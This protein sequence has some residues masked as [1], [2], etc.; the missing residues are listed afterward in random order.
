MEM[1]RIAALLMALCLVFQLV[2]APAGA[3][4]SPAITVGSAEAYPGNSFYINIEAT[5]LSNLASLDLEIYYDSENLTL[6]SVTNGSLLSGGLVS[7]N[8]ETPGVIKLSAAWLSGISED[9]RLLRLLF[10]VNSDAAPGTYRVLAAVGDAHDVNLNPV[11]ISRGAGTVTVKDRPTSA[12]NF[13]V[14]LSFAD[15]TTYHQG[16][17]VNVSLIN[18]GWQSFASGDFK[19][20]Y[21]S[22]LFAL[23]SVTLRSEM[24]VEGA[25]YSVN[26]D[27][28]GLVKVSYASVQP[29]SCY[30]LM[31]FV[32]TV[33]GDTD[34]ETTMTA[35]ATDVYTVDLVPYKPGSTNRSLTLEKKTAVPDYPDLY[36]TDLPTTVGQEGTTLLILEENSGVAAADFTV[37]YDPE[38]YACLEVTAAE[39]LSET[40]GMVVINPTFDEGSVK[41]SYINENGSDAGVELVSIQWK[42]LSSPQTHAEVLTGGTGIVNASF[43]SVK[44]DLVPFTGCIFD[45]FRT[46][47]TCTMDGEEGMMC[48]AC[49]EKKDVTVLSATGHSYGAAVTP[50]TCTEQGFTTHTC[51]VCGHSYVDEY[52]EATG[53]SYDD[54]YT[55]VEATCTETGTRKHD[56]RNCDHS[57]TEVTDALGHAYADGICTRCGAPESYL[58]EGKCGDT[59]YWRMGE[60]G[61]LTIFGTGSMYDFSSSK[62]G[63]WSAYKDSIMKVIV[64]EGATTI[65]SNAFRSYTSITDVKLPGTLQALNNSCFYGCE[66]LTSVLLTGQLKTIG[67]SA[68]SRCSNLE[69]VTLPDGLESIGAQAFSTCG[70]LKGIVI[71]DGVTTLGNFVFSNCWKLE[72][73]NIPEGVT[74]LGTMAFFS[75]GML[76]EIIIP[77]S[78]VSIGNYAFRYCDSLTSVVIPAGV[79]SLGEQAFDSCDALEEMWICSTDCTYA[80]NSLDAEATVFCYENST[81]HTYAVDNGLTY[82]AAPAGEDLG[83]V[84]TSQVTPP[85]C[86]EQ[87][88]T[89]HTCTRC[90][91]AVTDSYVDMLP[92]NF[93]QW[94]TTQEPGCLTTGTKQHDCRDCGYSETGTLDAL[95]HDYVAVVTEP[96]CTAQ[97]YTTHTCS[98]CGDSYKDSYTAALGHEYGSWYTVEEASCT[99]TGTER[100][101]CVRCEHY[102]TRAVDALGHD[103]VSAVTAPTCLEQGYT[104]HTCSRCGDSYADTYVTA[105]G[106]DYGQWITDREPTC[107]ETGSAHRDC[108]RCDSSETKVLA[109]TG[110]SYTDTV[111]PPTCTERGYTTHT[112]HCG[113]SYI[114]SYVAALGHA[115]EA[116][117]TAPTCLERGYTTY[118]CVRCDDTYVDDYVDAT[119]HS[120]GSWAV[121]VPATCTETG[122]DRRTCQN[123]DYSETRE[124]AIVPHSYASAVT[125]PDCVKQG[126]TT[127]TCNECG[128]SYVSDYTEPL[129]HAWDEGRVTVEPT[130]E[131]EGERVYTCTRCGETKTEVIPELEHVHSYVPSVTA[132]TCTEQGYTTYTCRCGDSYVQ[133]YVDALGH[134]YASEVTE[135]TC[136]EQ[137]Y[138]THTCSRCDHTYTDGYTEPL[139]HDYGDWVTDKAATCTEDGSAHRDCAR[140]ADRETKVLNKLGHDYV[141]VVTDPTCLDRGYTTH[142]CNRCH[143]TYTD[144]YTAALGHDYASVVTAPTCL[145]QGYTTH[146]CSRCDESYVDSYVAAL[147]HAYGEW[148]TDKAATCT[149]EGSAH[150][151]CDRCDSRETKV[152]DKLGHD[153]ESTVTDPTC[154][155]RGY[156]THRCSRCGNSYVDSYVDALGHAY[157][158]WITDQAPTCTEDGS[159]SRTC[160]RCGGRETQVLPMTGHSY[161]AETTAPTCTERGYT[162]YTC[163]CG[164][165]YTDNYVDTLGHDYKSVV[166]APTCTEQGYTT[167]TCTRCGHS[168][169]DAWLEALGHSWDEGVITKEP[170]EEE[171]GEMVYTCTVCGATDTK[172]LPELGHTHSYSA[173]VTA[174]TCTEEGYTTYTCRC[175]DS[176][177]DSYV[178]PLGHAYESV[179]TAPTCTEGGYTTHTCSRCGDAYTDTATDALG[180]AWDEGT[181]TKEPTESAVGEMTFTCTRCGETRKETLPALGHTHSYSTAVTA[182]TCTEQGYTTYTCAC[183]HSY[184][185]DHVPALG[186]NWKPADCDTCKTCT[187]CGVSEGDPLE[188]SWIAADCDSPKTCSRCGA[189][190]GSALGHDYVD[191]TCTRCG[192][193]DPNYEAPAN[194]SL[195]GVLRIAGA[196]R[197]ETSL[198]LADQLKETL[199]VDKF[200]A[201]IVAS[202]LNFPDA[203][204][205]SYLASVREAPILLTY[206]RAHGK[207]QAYID[208]NLKSGG[209]VYILGGE[210]AV[211][212]GFEL[213]LKAMGI[214]TKR[215]AGSDRFGTN[216]AIMREAGV[217]ASQPVL[218][219]TAINFADSLSASAAGLPMVLVYGSLRQEQKEFLATTSRNFII[220]GGTAAVS[221][222]LE[223]ELKAIGSVTRVAG[224]SRYETSVLVAQRFVQNPNAV[225]LAY[226]KNF[227]DGLCGGPLAYALGAPLILTD[228]SGYSTADTYVS[229]IAAGIVVGG[230]GLISDEVAREI[231]DLAADAVITAK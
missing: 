3:A 114:D 159:K 41:F 190:E 158:D 76:K 8:D 213:V 153:Y 69:S 196:D 52:T 68:F 188:H 43:A 226:A 84:N 169:T 135:P 225:I 184:V 9:G 199:G 179:V 181:V 216:L 150:R 136:L 187:R 24:A 90:G 231:F 48:N 224:S 127:Y 154:T 212:A 59:L 228:N 55:L 183:G 113:H 100:H 105:L 42:C 96:T 103:Y 137:G 112:C 201:V 215:V 106:H 17:T 7:V 75:C 143:H 111:T 157:G 191:G 152:L 211:S 93:G 202:A 98:R 107:T 163:H 37:K 53:H 160:S 92:H 124:T 214:H 206:E 18:S 168:Y 81:A 155:D 205:G 80:A 120:M 60:D 161:T 30:N 116:T 11:E 50:P 195:S 73:A 14:S 123:C 125:E 164:D 85:T 174:P 180:H 193:D 219:A 194:P 227:P 131:T 23:E 128:H 39:G 79:T 151:E 198:M 189:T 47:P 200:D 142:T 175:G 144:A 109:A 63:P 51:A 58:E 229:G 221:E 35:S 6:S 171:A 197:I 20:E 77:E 70:K 71:P 45:S 86:T 133:E 97:G 147:G 16:D 46:E 132:P 21:D 217:N 28:A 166:T 108:S 12:G 220:I 207:I 118:T 185:G 186:H 170:T 203:L 66:G 5:G 139:G 26:R 44:L 138:T 64:N 88:Y 210:S 192:E 204:T 36:L 148:I 4:E 15:G 33:I 95:G 57:E 91:H 146:T 94:Y 149:E 56:C 110:H 167:H 140:C 74:A 176:F 31:D 54:W 2:P 22:K 78:M 67:D 104:T 102:E 165:S 177:V 61:T 72:Y 230:N 182:P 208:A 173:E 99:A 141:S 126:Y 117:V 13:S 40:G 62:T 218:I 25:V 156:T 115:Y 38:V 134:D 65:G 101:D 209:T 89:T 49:G 222:S 83:H 10:T 172:V 130:E 27:I 34:T 82:C 19:L 29:V 145:E 119:G 1:K 178:E 122:L 87:G 129:G 162:T 223:A 32:L 121:E